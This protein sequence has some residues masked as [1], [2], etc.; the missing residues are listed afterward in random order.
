MGQSS[1]DCAA[2]RHRKHLS[3]ALQSSEGRGTYD[4]TRVANRF[5]I[6]IVFSVLVARFPDPIRT[7]QPP[8]S[9]LARFVHGCDRGIHRLGH[10][11]FRPAKRGSMLVGL[12]EW[13]T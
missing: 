7:Q 8:I 12:G 13:I 9:V 6:R 3:L 11:K 1:T 2:S 4:P 10:H 5:K